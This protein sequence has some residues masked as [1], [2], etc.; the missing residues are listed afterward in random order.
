VAGLRE[1]QKED[2]QTSIARAAKIMFLEHGFE[3]ATIEGIAQAAGVSGVTVHN[4]YGTKSGILL[5]LV[6]ENDRSLIASLNKELSLCP[7][8]VTEVT[9]RFAKTILEHVLMNLQKVIWRQVIATVTAN[10]DNSISKPYFDLDQE[11]AQVLV[12]QISRMQDA[13]NLPKSIV[14]E[15]LGE[16]LFHLQ[17]A[18]FIQFVCSDELQIEDVLR[19]IRNDLEALF[20]VQAAVSA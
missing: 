20:A 9:V 8:E 17:N 10:A 14:P 16:A 19:R 18:R 11:L 15:N 2:R 7:Q 6:A 5:A 4:Y 1:R 13:G 12:L 3:K